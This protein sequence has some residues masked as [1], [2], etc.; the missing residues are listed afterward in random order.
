MT[1]SRV[2]LWFRRPIATPTQAT[3]D[4]LG[5]DIWENKTWEKK[6]VHGIRYFVRA[7]R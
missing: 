1:E 4:L 6:I 7:S 5:K 3:G 2:S